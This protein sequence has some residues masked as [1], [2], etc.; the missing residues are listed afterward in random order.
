MNT[1]KKKFICKIEVNQKIK[2][3]SFSFITGPNVPVI[4]EKYRFDNDFALIIKGQSV[5][6]SMSEILWHLLRTINFMGE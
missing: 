2:P 6:R 4:N 3:D 1:T 5:A